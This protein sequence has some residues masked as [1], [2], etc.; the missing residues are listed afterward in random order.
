MPRNQASRSIVVTF[1]H[2]LTAAV[3]L[4]PASVAAQAA[5]YRD[6]LRVAVERI[7]YN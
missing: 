6:G 7:R 3:F 2:I 4:T 5:A 1:V